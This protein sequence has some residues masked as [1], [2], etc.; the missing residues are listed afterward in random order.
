MVLLVSVALDEFGHA[1]VAYKLGDDTPKRQGRVTLNPLAHADPIGTFLLPL[2]GGVVAA[3]GGGVGGFGWGKPV[4][5][6]P[7]RVRRGISTST[8]SI[9]VSFAGPAMNLL[10]A[11]V[12]AIV[13]VV[14]WSQQ[15][16][17]PDSQ[18]HQILFFAATT[19]FVL[20]F[21]NLLP[22][23]PLDGGHIAQAFVPYR[24]RASF[25]R[26]AK[27]GPFILLAVMLVPQLRQVFLAPALWCNQHL[28]QALASIFT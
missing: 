27:Y 16:L 6:Q 10:L 19:N 4:Q 23:P 20:F 14:L 26:V 8:A 7:H 25:D 2:V 5:W 15:V 17:A 18:M 12:V 24:H 28:Y 11:T 3:S 1:V 13:H 9:L 21:F 22:L